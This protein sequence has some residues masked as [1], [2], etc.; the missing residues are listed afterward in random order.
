MRKIILSLF[1]LLSALSCVSYRTD[2]SPPEHFNYSPPI[3]TNPVLFELGKQVP[4]K[5]IILLQEEYEY[6]SQ[7][8]K[9]ILKESLAQR[10]FDGSII[11]HRDLSVNEYGQA[12]HYVEH[13]PFIYLDRFE[14]RKYL[15]HIDVKVSNSSGETLRQF[16]LHFD[17]NGQL[18]PLP[19]E[20]DLADFNAIAIHPWFFLQQQSVLWRTAI[21]PINGWPQRSFWANGLNYHFKP[22]RNYD[23]YLVRGRGLRVQV[24][25]E[26]KDAGLPRIGSLHWNGETLDLKT[27]D[28]FGPVFKQSF[29]IPDG[30]NYQFIYQYK[31]IKD[32]PPEW[33]VQ[34]KDL[35]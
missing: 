13:Q 12:L 34:P 2:T 35:H 18:Q 23:A 19:D 31:Q 14:E 17:W 28:F 15:D 9:P 24:A 27:E 8:V 16:Q 10:N 29:T 33:I 1:V 21:Q 25:L 22:K 20:M 26:I 32:I 5:A 30:I 4:N 3:S 7:P 11:N 6:S